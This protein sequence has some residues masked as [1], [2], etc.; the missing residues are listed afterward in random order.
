MSDRYKPTAHL[1][2]FYTDNIS[3]PELQQWWA[4][5]DD[6]SPTGHLNEAVGEW[7]DLP[8]NIDPQTKGNSDNE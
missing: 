4:L 1:R 6:G 8:S 2:W 5:P 7:R 3:E